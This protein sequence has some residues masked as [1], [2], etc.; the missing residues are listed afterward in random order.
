MNALHTLLLAEAGIRPIVLEIARAG[1]LNS[2]NG[3]SDEA[4]V[5]YHFICVVGIDANGYW[6]NDGDNSAITDHLVLYP[7]SEL[8]QAVPCGVLVLN[9]QEANPMI[10]ITAVKDYFTASKDGLTWT[11]NNGNTLHG[12]I[13]TFWR[14][15][16]NPL[17]FP[18]LPV[19]AET[20][21]F[22][23]DANADKAKVVVQEFE[24]A[25]VAYDPKR[26]MDKPLNVTGACYYAHVNALGT[27]SVY[28]ADLVKQ[29]T[30]ANALIAQLEDELKHPAPAV[31]TPQ[32]QDVM[33]A[34]GSL[35]KAMQEGATK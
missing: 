10:D 33:N 34:F 16:S 31:L 25:E 22:A 18:G 24:R 5:Q 2:Y 30:A 28:D 7:W 27:K 4:G 35:V 23:G 3:G 9:M 19:S 26:L 17:G 1:Q 6:C 20:L 21:P 15:Q 13:L 11:C 29:L 14:S 8:Q 32:Q 12:G